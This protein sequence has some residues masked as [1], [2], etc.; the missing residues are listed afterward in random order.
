[1]RGAAGRFLLTCVLFVLA[2]ALTFSLTGC[3]ESGM[4]KVK[5]VKASTIIWLKEKPVTCGVEGNFD[6]CAEF[7]TPTR[8]VCRIQM[9]EDSSD[10]VIAHEFRHCFGWDHRSPS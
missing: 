2:L 3:D 6:G 5:E 8:S 4:V 7:L 9:L 1:M 10:Y